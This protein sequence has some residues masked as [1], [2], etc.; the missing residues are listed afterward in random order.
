MEKKKILEVNGVPE[1]HFLR[2]KRLLEFQSMLE[3]YRKKQ[4]ERS[5]S[6]V[7]KLLKEEKL[8]QQ[9][10]RK[11]AHEQSEYTLQNVSR[12][13]P[14]RD[15]LTAPSD[16]RG[17][18]TD[19]TVPDE[20]FAEEGGDAG[21]SGMS[22]PTDDMLGDCEQMLR[23]K[24]L[25]NIVEPEIPGLW[26]STPQAAEPGM[27]LEVS[28]REGVNGGERAEKELDF[29][30]KASKAEILIMKKAMEKL[31]D[32]KVQEQVAAGRKFKAS[33]MCH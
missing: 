24:A 10:K 15:I 22:S 2:K 4:E 12:K 33:A 18:H 1:E 28:D 19:S 20:G 6:I 23:D 3:N 13:A 29:K 14:K 5:V 21:S 11:H 27:P 26:E 30:Q 25:M 8:K 31:K 7:E 16:S 17:K 9:T 32:S